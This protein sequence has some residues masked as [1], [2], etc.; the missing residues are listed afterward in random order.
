MSARALRRLSDTGMDAADLV[1]HA[2]WATEAGDM[3]MG[4][5]P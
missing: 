1:G 3:Q 2:N 5:D 4:L